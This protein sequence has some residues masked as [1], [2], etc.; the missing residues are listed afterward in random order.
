MR[1]GILLLLL[2]GACG[3]VGVSTGTRAGVTPGQSSTAPKSNFT[4][5]L[6]NPLSADQ[7]ATE[8]A[9]LPLDSGYTCAVLVVNSDV[10]IRSYKNG[11]PDFDYRLGT[12]GA[13]SEIKDLVDGNEL[14]ASSFAGEIT[15]R[16]IQ[17]VFWSFGVTT[18]SQPVSAHDV[19]FNVDQAGTSAN[20]LTPTVSVISNTADIAHCRVDVYSL[21]QDQWFAE[22]QPFMSGEFALLTRYQLEAKGALSVRRMTK[23]LSLQTNGAYLDLTQTYVWGITPF[24]F[25]T[26][27]TGA[28]STYRDFYVENWMPFAR[29]Q[30]NALALAFDDSGEPSWWYDTTDMPLYPLINIKSTFGYATVFNGT[31]ALGDNTAA[32]INL[33]VVYGTKNGTCVGVS[34]CSAAYVLN[35][36]IF[37]ASTPTSTNGGIMVLPGLVL[38]DVPVSTVIDQTL[39]IWP[40]RGRSSDSVTELKTLS[41][42]LSAV[43]IY[44]PGAS[45][46]GETAILSQKLLSSGSTQRVDHLAPLLS[47]L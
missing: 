9:A 8:H 25:G 44:Y 19:R 45:P 37:D 33:S 24:Q 31:A 43:K 38:G 3:D 46:V 39:Y 1:S 20:L 47:N 17:Q 30:F 10:Y 16:V 34:S 32:G 15:D 11:V 13:L 5:A 4:A 26:P 18:P 27:A 12:G 29:P 36:G 6:T 22:Y 28:Q 41:S 2:L 21:P 40:T 23:L 14:I 42:A 7:D 35:S